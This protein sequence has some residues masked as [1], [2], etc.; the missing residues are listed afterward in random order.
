M[1][2]KNQYGVRNGDQWGVRSEANSR[3]TGTFNTQ[4]EAIE[5]A[6]PIA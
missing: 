5:R 3:L 2:G 6:R 4:R 1:A